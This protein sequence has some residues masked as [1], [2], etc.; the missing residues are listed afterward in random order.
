MSL[1]LETLRNL[2]R[3]PLRNALTATGL[4]IGIMAL[5]TM[6]ALAERVNALLDGGTQ[7]FS[8]HLVITEATGRGLG[9]GGVLAAD[10]A[11][12]VARVEGVA[13][14][15]PTVAL[16]AESDRDA[17]TAPARVNAA[18]P[19]FSARIR[20][21]LVLE[22]GR[23]L[24]PGRRGE[25]VLGHDLAGRLGARVG[26]EVR[27]PLR[28]RLPAAGFRDH[29]FRVVGIHE[30]T[31]SQ[32]DNVAY[33]GFEE[34]Q[35]LLAEGLPEALRSA[36]DPALIAT[37]ISAFGEPGVDL[38]ALAR[39]ISILMPEL[40]A[41]P[42]GELVSQFREGS[43]YFTAL[44][45]GSAL[46]ALVIGGLSVVNT[47]LM[48]V[49]ERGREIGIKKAVGAH[50]A[51]VG[52]EYLLETAVFALLGGALGVIAGLAMIRLLGR[53]ASGLT[54]FLVTPRLLLLAAVAALV[55]G[56]AAGVLPALRAA[57]LDPVQAIRGL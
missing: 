23:E 34:G 46:L 11:R 44:A 45:T 3:R 55:L 9:G 30:K 42:P 8:D 29:P 5:V 53:L 40:R 32:P 33:V 47:M 12:E 35:Q 52:R 38:D 18:P 56:A 51:D 57:R 1:F 54:L 15:Y 10:R 39:R 6:G 27:F 31:L 49:T 19:G 41:I 50:V 26:A 2:G 21:R 14:A 4:M 36:V 17:T 25:V 20:Y 22:A 28:P 7:F 16:S 43:F 24:D 37:G 13:A 48:A